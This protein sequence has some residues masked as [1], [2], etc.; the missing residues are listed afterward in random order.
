MNF[1]YFIRLF[2]SLSMKLDVVDNDVDLDT[3]LS[4]SLTVD[5]VFIFSF[6]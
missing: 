3:S 2:T 1:I 4:R 6:S 5:S